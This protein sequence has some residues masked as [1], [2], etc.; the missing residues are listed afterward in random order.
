MTLPG[1]GGVDAAGQ[2][3]YSIP[4]QVPPGTA[5]MAPGLSLSYS[6]RNGDGFEGFGWALNGLDVI[7]HCQAT[8]SID[9]SRGAVNY[10][11][12]DKFCLNGSHLMVQTGTYGADGSTY[13]AYITSFAKIIFHNPTG[14]PS[15]F[16]MHLPSGVEEDLG[17]TSDSQ[18]DISGGSTAREWHVNKIIDKKGNYLTVT[19]N[20]DPTNGV[21]YPKH[22][23]YTGN[24][25]ASL[26]TYNNVQF[27]Y[28]TAVR[29]DEVP[30]YKGGQLTQIP[31]LLTD[32]VTYNGPYSGPSTAVLDYKLAYRAG[33]TTTHS[34]LTS[35]TQCDGTGVNCLAPTTF[36]WQGGTG[37]PTYS[38]GDPGVTGVSGSTLLAGEF[39][40]DGL[41]DA[42]ITGSCPS[43]GDVYAGTGVGSATFSSSSVTTSYVYWNTS[44]S[45]VTYSGPVCFNTLTPVVGNF[46]VTGIS[47]LASP[48]TYWQSGTSGNTTTVLM[49]WTSGSTL[50]QNGTPPFNAPNYIPPPMTIFGDFDGDGLTDG[51]HQINTTTGRVWNMRVDG[52]FWQESAISG[53]GT[54]NTL[55]TGDFNGDGCTDLFAQGTTSAVTFFCSSGAASATVPNYGG[56]VYV[57]DFNGDGNA[58]VLVVTSSGATIY[59]STGEGM[60]A[61]LPVTGSSGWSGHQ[62]VLGDWNGDGKTDVAVIGASGAAHVIYLSTGSDFSMITSVS[63][64]GSPFGVAADWNSDGADDIWLHQSG[65][66]KVISFQFQPEFITAVHNGIGATTSISY[67]PLNTNGTYYTKQSITVSEQMDGAYYAVSRIGVDDG[68]GVTAYHTDYSYYTAVLDTTMPPV[69]TQRGVI[70]STFLAFSTITAK[71]SRAGNPTTLMSYNTTLPLAGMLAESKVTVGT[72]IISQT[73]YTYNAGGVGGSTAPTLSKVVHTRNDLNGTALPTI[74]TDYTSYDAYNNPLTIVTTNQADGSTSTVTNTF[75]NDT[76]NW[77]LGE[78]TSTVVENVVGTSDITRHF[79]YT[80]DP[81]TGYNAKTVLEQGSSTLEFDTNYYFDSFGN[82]NKVQESGIDIATR[83]TQIAYD[84]L[85]EFQNTVTNPLLQATTLAF[86]ARFGGATTATDPNSVSASLSY[87]T[88]GRA[89][90]LTKGNGT[91]VAVG[92]S[93]CA[94]VNGGTTSCPTHAAYVVTTEPESPSSTQAG[95]IQKAYYDSLGRVL[96]RDTQGLSG[97]EIRVNTVYDS[98]GNVAES[99]RPYFVGGLG[100]KYTVYTYDSLHRATGATYPDSSTQGFCYNGLTTSFTNQDSQ[101]KVTVRNNQGQVSSVTDNA[102]GDCNATGVTG[103]TSRYTYDAFGDVLTVKDPSSNTSTYTYD[104]RGRKTGAA[105][106]DRGGTAHPWT[107][108]YYVDSTFKNQTDAN[109]TSTSTVQT[110]DKLLRPL[111]RTDAGVITSKES[112][113]TT[114]GIGNL[115]NACVAATCPGAP[116]NLVPIYDTK[117]RISTQQIK[118]DGTTYDYGYT[119]DDTA[120]GGGTGTGN[121]ASV[122][123]PSGFRAD[124]SYNTY[125]YLSQITDHGTGKTIWQANSADAELHLTQQTQG[126]AATPIT[127]TANYDPNTGR[128]L[129]QCAS[130][131]PGPCD[132]NVLG[133]AYNWDP[134]GNLNYRQDTLEGY[135]EHFCY[136]NLNRLTKSSTTGA[137]CSSGSGSK[138]LLYSPSGNITKKTDICNTTSCMVYGGGGNAGPHA[139]SSIVGTYNGV[140]NP[141]FTY[142]NDGN[143]LTGANVSFGVTSFGQTSTITQGTTQMAELAYGAFHQRY[144]MCVPNCTSPTAT[145][146]YLADP[147]TGMYSEKVA[148]S[149]ATI[150]SDYIVV[151][152]AGI[153]A[154]R[155]KNGG[156]VLWRYAGVDHLGSV[157]TLTDPQTPVVTERNSYDPW[158]KRRNADGSDNTTCSLT[159]QITRGFTGQEMLDSVCLINM[160]ARLYDPSVSRFM[161]AD[162]RLPNLYGT[163]DHNRYSYTYDNPLNATDPTGHV[164]YGYGP[165]SQLSNCTDD[166][167]GIGYHDSADSLGFFDFGGDN[168]DADRGG[169]GDGGL[170]FKRVRGGT[171]LTYVY[172][173]PD[174]FENSVVDFF[175]DAPLDDSG[176]ADDAGSGGDGRGLVC[177]LLP[178]AR[179]VGVNG[180]IGGTTGPTGGFEVVTNYNTN[181]T[182]VFATVG[183]FVGWNY[184]AQANF[185][186]GFVW[187]L[188]SDNNNYSKGFASLSGGDVF[189]L[190]GQSSIPKSGALELGASVGTSLIP[191]PTGGA[192][193]TYSWP[194]A[195]LNYPIYAGPVDYI[196]SAAKHLA[197]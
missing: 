32:I 113:D 176:L 64:S 105:I 154:V 116:Y 160:N 194:I 80:P 107:F 2:F 57:G 146:D 129:A 156:T 127:E 69:P 90:V 95:A 100:P 161:G 139:L 22:I 190:Y 159:S 38:T 128:I 75:T 109:S 60:S 119:Y 163:Q 111:T 24:A 172:T 193:T 150:Y 103:T 62:I 76:T 85:G 124:Y 112:W 181:Q 51:F 134:L 30:T 170:S 87:D 192:A 169:R 53:L 63:G 82:V 115:M 157:V 102:S 7:S 91:E 31:Y 142:D 196:L 114:N 17:N 58:D 123:Y 133:F 179:T 184:G 41:T 136:D 77:I 92:Y 8:Q 84:A 132:G 72:Q 45:P 122:T 173:G 152:G 191:G 174:G 94:G 130:T 10:N 187:N 68:A 188:G 9:G 120:T 33:T 165:W 182:T 131:D 56:T 110:Y 50:M 162:D 106:P 97:N 28:T 37:L 126:P 40:N 11:A 186:T 101:I 39:T 145:T 175:P 27:V 178:D 20:N 88:L 79:N 98:D 46:D 12:N 66:E 3:N 59:L 104:V 34:R 151:P 18:L 195:N 189:G 89:N 23:D 67:L 121:I 65:S 71:D 167:G 5:G 125:G 78:L 135:T 138:G 144:K 74:E 19:Y 143:M 158:G 54:N 36:D 73:D 166:C 15:W 70:P 99:S 55:Y 26:A 14:G 197:C 42:L 35:V 96:Y 108:N 16:E 4:I 183:G 61:G 6:S 153:V 117:T 47:D 177:R 43:G 171:L 164:V 185:T 141:T 137:T 52:N 168:A 140:T 81:T 149:S 180:T 13:Y 49:N 148:T 86:D 44:H 21:V 155:I 83:A 118:L 1:G 147:M 29:G 48:E 25:T 93:F